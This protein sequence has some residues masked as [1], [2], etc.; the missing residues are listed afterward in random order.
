MTIELA[1]PLS[2]QSAR[3]RRHGRARPK[4]GM[5]QDVSYDSANRVDK[6]KIGG[7]SSS[8]TPLLVLSYS[9]PA[10]R[11][12]PLASHRCRTRT[13]RSSWRRPRWTPTRPLMKRHVSTPHR[14]T[15]RRGVQHGAISHPQA[16]DVLL[17]QLVRHAISR[18][19]RCH[20]CCLSC[21]FNLPTLTNRL[22]R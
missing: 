4:R 7:V 15:H 18:P 13:R 5:G 14:D 1:T 9:G 16:A 8:R 20:L 12:G 22:E 21:D 3:A 17:G 10:V 6:E 11:V 2:G 19:C